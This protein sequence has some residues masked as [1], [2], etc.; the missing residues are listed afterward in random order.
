MPGA[1]RLFARSFRIL[2]PSKGQSIRQ[3]D[4]Q[5]SAIPTRLLRDLV[6]GDDFGPLLGV[7]ETIETD[8]WKGAKPFQP[9]PLDT[10]V[11]GKNQ[12]R[13]VDKDRI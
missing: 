1:R 10:T 13:V 2:R 4:R 5:D 11:V 6:V 3:L 8:N 9:H 12:I 7:G